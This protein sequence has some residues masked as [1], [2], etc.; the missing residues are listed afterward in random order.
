MKIQEIKHNHSLT[1]LLKILLFAILMLAPALSVASRCL[2]V[3]VNKNAYQSYSDSLVENQ[4]LLTNKDQLQTGSIQQ[5]N[6]VEDNVQ[7]Y[8]GWFGFTQISL[9]LSQLFTE[10]NSNYTY[11]RIRTRNDGYMYIYDSS[12]SGSTITQRIW[13][14]SVFNFSI[15]SDG[16]FSEN[17]YTSG[18]GSA[19]I[20]QYQYK[21]NNLDNVFEY[22]VSKLEDSQMFNWTTN[23]AIFTG[24]QAMCS[25]LGIT[26][27]VIAEILVYW[28]LLTVIYVIIDIILKTFTVITHML[29]SKKA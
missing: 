8:T 16:Y 27:P 9:D 7:E 13:G 29:G 26:T 22:S 28:F 21:N 25:Q 23:T 24:V 19:L 18:L 12:V 3:I 2:Y 1:D 15:V 17:T 20:Y 10:Y 11:D 6:Y 14:V 5:F 4:I